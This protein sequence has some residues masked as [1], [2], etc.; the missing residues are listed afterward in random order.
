MK[1]LLALALVACGLVA[2]SAGAVVAESS[3]GAVLQLSPVRQSLTVS[4]GKTGQVRLTVTNP[5]QK[6]LTLQPVV[7][8]FTAGDSSGTPALIM[9]QSSNTSGRSF[10]KFAS[11]PGQLTVPP[12]GAKDLTITVTVPTDST[13]GGYYGAVRL[14]PVGDS[15]SGGS[16]VRTNAASLVLLKV[17]GSVKEELALTNFTLTPTSPRLRQVWLG[18]GK[19]QVALEFA[20][21]GDVHEAPV[22]QLY[23]KRGGAVVDTIDFN[24]TEPRSYIL[25]ES[26]RSWRLELETPADF[27]HYTLGGVFTYGDSNKTIEIKRSFWVVPLIYL[28]GGSIG[29]VLVGLLAA[30]LLMRRSAKLRPRYYNR[31]RRR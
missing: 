16:A 9:D 17:P 19:M 15:S 31:H 8:D 12:D 10:K 25:P 28:I 22:G 11:A 6:N 26:R 20:N 24:Q 4:P 30:A 1:K 18:G 7:E 3:S 29:V 2:M 27:G 23:L 13:P 5:T 14:T 21:R